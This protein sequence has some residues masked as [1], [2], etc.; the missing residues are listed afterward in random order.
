MFLS[1]ISKKAG[2]NGLTICSCDVVWQTLCRDVTVTISEKINK[3][4]TS[5]IRT[6]AHRDIHLP[7]VVT[8][9]LSSLPIFVHIISIKT[10]QFYCARHKGQLFTSIPMMQKLTSYSAG[11]MTGPEPRAIRQD[12][13]IE[14]PCTTF[15]QS[16][17]LK[18]KN[19]RTQQNDDIQKITFYIFKIQNC[20]IMLKQKLLN[21]I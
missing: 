19:W 10:F 15:W 14:T 9:E 18:W 16:L 8:I 12:T 2:K 5:R 17:Q 13:G 11:G 21:I 20:E 1:N 6:P 4:L 3:L 7:C